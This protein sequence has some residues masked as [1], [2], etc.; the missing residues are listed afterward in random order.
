VN[1]AHAASLAPMLGYGGHLVC[2]QGRV[3]QHP[4]PP[5]SSAVSLH[6]LAL[7]SIHEHGVRADWLEYRA[8]GESMLQQL[9]LRT[10]AA[11]TIVTQPF[12][13]LPGALAALKSGQPGKQIVLV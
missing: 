3:E 7:G 1:A 11:P 2:I 10:L 8:A 9:A 4:L 6:E 13:E 5:F 12:D